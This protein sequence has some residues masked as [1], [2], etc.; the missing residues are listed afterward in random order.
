MHTC[1]KNVEI[2]E[3]NIGFDRENNIVLENLIYFNKTC[4][5]DAKIDREETGFHYK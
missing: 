4:N 3:V 2:V 1:N 5:H